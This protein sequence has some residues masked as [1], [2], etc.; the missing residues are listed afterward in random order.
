[1]PGL[2]FAVQ[3][4]APFECAQSPIAA[5]KLSPS[6]T[7]WLIRHAEVES[8]YQQVFGGRIDMDLSARGQ[9]QAASLAKYLHK[10][11]LQVLYASPMR[12]VQQTLIP[13][14]VNGAPEP[15]ILPE[16]REVDFGDWTGLAWN[17]VQSEFGISPFD[18]LDLLESNRIP[19]AECAQS[20]RSRLEP[21]LVRILSN[22]PGQQ[23]AIACHGGVIRMIL[24]ILLGWP[25]TRFGSVEI[26][27]ASITQIAWLSGRPKLQLVNFAPWRDLH[28]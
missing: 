4:T 12:R 14:V 9:Q 7:L 28:P 2:G 17:E 3:T 26:E 19:K 20:L 6:T 24:A 8:R 5:L 22:H 1:M 10:Q 11:R 27:Y 25:F 23:I 15:I 13:F 18:W 21:C 16:L